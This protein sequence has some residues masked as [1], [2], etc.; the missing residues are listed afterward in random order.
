MKDKIRKSLKYSFLDGAFFSIM[1]GF[2]DSY[3]NPYAI[4]LK[5]SNFQIGLLSSL[6]GF[7]SAL[8][9]IHTPDLTEKIGR[10]RIISFGIF[11]QAF[12][13][14]PIILIPIIFKSN[15]IPWLI[16]AVT[17]YVL[18]S[19]IAVPAWASIILQYIP[20]K[21]RGHYFSWRQ[22]ITGIITLAATFCAAII[23]TLFPRQSL[24]GFTLIFSFAMSARFMSWYFLTKMYEPKI[25]SKPGSYFTLW[26]FLSRSHKSNYAK[27]VFF[28]GAISFSVYLSSPFF[29]VYMLRE[30]KFDYISYVFINII[31]TAAM[32]ISL[33]A[34]GKNADKA[35]C[36]QVI[37]LTSIILPVLPVLW[38]FSTSKI[39]LVL[40]QVLSGFAWGGYN[41]AISNF[42]YDA[43]SEEKRVRCIAYFNLINGLGMFLGA[44]TGGA[45]IYKLPYIYGS[46]LLTIFLIS[47][48][49]RAFVRIIMIPRLKEVKKVSHIS[50]LH[51]FLNV[52]G[53]NKN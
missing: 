30:L 32:L 49:L 3:L 47:G 21:K 23:L 16:L 25:F 34:W 18:P 11:I 5:A 52:V 17:L 20:N 14:M 44:V 10:S 9:Q 39:Y 4:L 53:L 1:F 6:P 24:Y 31:P 33:P 45:V 36:M 48:V 8:F 43:V 51:L 28:A 7:I 40:I 38:L 29:A 12:L 22:R 27:F 13:W 50:N 46:K 42:I 2:G 35:G 26:D 37:R 41:L 19:S 15:P